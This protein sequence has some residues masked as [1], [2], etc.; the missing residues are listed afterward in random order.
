MLFSEN[1][2][3]I[4]TP[5]GLDLDSQIIELC[6]EIMGINEL[7]IPFR[8][9]ITSDESESTATLGEDYRP[10]I[11]TPEGCPFSPFN[12]PLSPP[13][14]PNINSMTNVVFDF[15]PGNV[16][17]ACNFVS[18]MSD[19]VLEG[20]EYVKF[21]IN[22]TEPVDIPPSEDPCSTITIVDP[23]G[24]IAY[25]YNRTRPLSTLSNVYRCCSILI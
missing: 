16:T 10:G 23:E 20:S 25:Y 6:V 13:L 15:V 12:V 11:V 1:S 19:S 9:V 4:T 7:E 8:V 22:S 21:I 3:L 18:I 17:V 2:S 24:P 5:E 14:P